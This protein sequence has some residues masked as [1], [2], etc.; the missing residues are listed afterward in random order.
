MTVSA[1]A[2]L[3]YLQLA[4][5][6]DEDWKRYIQPQSGTE[7]HGRQIDES[8]RGHHTPVVVCDMHNLNKL[9]RYYTSLHVNST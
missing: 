3:A 4:P 5:W 6:K 2:T 1:R 7:E 8:S 9:P